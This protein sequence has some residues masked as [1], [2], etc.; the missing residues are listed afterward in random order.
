LSYKRDLI[1]I[2]SNSWG[3]GDRGFEVKGP[4]PLL[5]EVLENG[6]RLG[7]GGKGSIFVFAAGNGGIIGDSCAFSGYVNNIHTIAIS[8]VN[9]DGSVPAYTEDCAS[10]MAVT[11][12]QD[13]F[14]YGKFVPPLQRVDVA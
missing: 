11:Y 5:K 3:P 9:W 1:D 2:Y 13:M 10:I 6:T 4:G 7:R 12:G 8:G 14:R